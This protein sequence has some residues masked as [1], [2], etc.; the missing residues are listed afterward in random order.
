MD[1][2]DKVHFHDTQFV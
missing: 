2:Q 1:A